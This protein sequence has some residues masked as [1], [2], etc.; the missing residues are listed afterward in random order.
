MKSYFLINRAI[1]DLIVYMWLYASFP[2]MHSPLSTK[3]NKT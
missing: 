1:T 3:N 2:T